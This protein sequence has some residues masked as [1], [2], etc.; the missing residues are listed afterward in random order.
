MKK[1]LVVGMILLF[2][3]MTLATTLCATPETLT[4]NQI[5]VNGH[6][7]KELTNHTLTVLFPTNGTYI[8]NFKI[9]PKPNNEA[10]FLI[11][12][13][14]TIPVKFKVTPPIGIFE[15]DYWIGP[16]LQYVYMGPNPWENQSIIEIGITP[17]HINVSQTVVFHW[18]DGTSSCW[19]DNIYKWL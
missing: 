16:Y 8:F 9:S 3:G 4:A 14:L 1:I 11:H 13:S 18:S 17:M 2:F 15:I 6:H 10:I 12:P 7:M 19:V 5:P